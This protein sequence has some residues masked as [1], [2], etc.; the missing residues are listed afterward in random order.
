[1]IE[2]SFIYIKKKYKYINEKLY[3][4][5]IEILERKDKIY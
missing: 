2:R 3:L 4:F 5:I 1:M